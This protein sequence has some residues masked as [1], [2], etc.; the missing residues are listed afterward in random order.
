MEKF[1]PC[2]RWL[3]TNRPASSANARNLPALA[4][5]AR[6]PSRRAPMSSLSSVK[7]S[8]ARARAS[9][10]HPQSF[11]NQCR[12]ACRPLRW[13][14]PAPA[15][16]LRS[17]K[18]S[19]CQLHAMP[20]SPINS[21]S[22]QS[23]LVI[24]HGQAVEPAKKKNAYPHPVG[25]TPQPIVLPNPPPSPHS[26]APAHRHPPPRAPSPPRFPCLGAPPVSILRLSDGF[27]CGP[28]AVKSLLPFPFLPS[29]WARALPSDTCSPRK[30][31]CNPK[32]CPLYSARLPN[33]I[34]DSPR[35]IPGRSDVPA[36]L[37]VGHCYFGSFVEL[38][39]APHRP[40]KP[41]RIKPSIPLNPPQIEL[42]EA[43]IRFE[44]NCNPE[45][46]PPTRR[47]VRYHQE[48]RRF[49]QFFTPSIF[50]LSKTVFPTS[51]P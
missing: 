24:S 7:N 39:Q 29:R 4:F 14:L 27:F 3:Q 2:A 15:R 35:T 12:P 51:S 45:R 5:W 32:P 8:K 43:R 48:L 10:L 33:E 44:A 40:A 30:R 46:S 36:L 28:R 25:R 50:E 16:I 23:P 31:P 38:A 26:R 34:V 6:F 42:L 18:F 22:S 41:P 9:P 11:Q 17:S 20:L 21:P 47:R 19:H 37:F 1:L 13:T 49:R